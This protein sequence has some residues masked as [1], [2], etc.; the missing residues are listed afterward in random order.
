M[1]S[2]SH[3]VKLNKE[4]HICSTEHNRIG[5]SE[6]SNNCSAAWQSAKVR[7]LENDLSRLKD[8]I[9]LSDIVESDFVSAPTVVDD[10]NR[11]RSHDRG[12]QHSLLSHT[13]IPTHYWSARASS[14]NTRNFAEAFQSISRAQRSKP[15]NDN[16]M[17]ETLNVKKSGCCFEVGA[18][19]CQIG[20]G[21]M[22]VGIS[23]R[24]EC[25]WGFLQHRF[26]AYMPH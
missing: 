25:L 2:E 3:R 8:G 11:K 4:Q 23:L 1:Q 21:F 10:E 6:V 15:S 26:E 5:G 7:L 18:S 20:T 22:K 12:S 13:D 17:S 14:S 19:E 24:L 16:L 9:Q